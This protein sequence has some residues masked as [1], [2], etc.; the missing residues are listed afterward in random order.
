MAYS[1]DRPEDSLS[2]EAVASALEDIPPE[3]RMEWLAEVEARAK[4]RGAQKVLDAIRDWRLEQV[5]RG[6]GT[7]FSGG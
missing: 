3:K 1:S 6:P 2:K 4:E 5:I 7:P